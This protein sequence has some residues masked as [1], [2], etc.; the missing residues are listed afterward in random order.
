MTGDGVVEIGK[1]KI[2]RFRSC[3]RLIL[4]GGLEFKD[5][6]IVRLWAIVQ[7]IEQLSSTTTSIK[8]LLV[9][10]HHVVS[11]RILTYLQQFYLSIN[12]P[13]GKLSEDAYQNDERR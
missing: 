5:I 9:K 8:I 13:S 6:E 11:W 1:I 3:L 12:L 4:G 2:G 7:F 10:D